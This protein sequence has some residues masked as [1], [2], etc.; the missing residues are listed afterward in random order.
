[1]FCDQLQCSKLEEKIKEIIDTRFWKII[2][3]IMSNFIRLCDLCSVLID[4]FCF[5]FILFEYA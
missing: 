1:V 2:G 5:E 4:N 3:F